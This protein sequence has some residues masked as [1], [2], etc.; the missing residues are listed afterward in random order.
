MIEVNFIVNHATE[1]CLAAKAEENC[2]GQSKE[3]S[4]LFE[5]PFGR[6]F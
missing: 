2:C 4:K 3:R 5:S 6:Q 1:K